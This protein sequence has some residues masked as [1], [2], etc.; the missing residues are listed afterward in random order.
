VGQPRKRFKDS[1]VTVFNVTSHKTY[2]LYIAEEF[3]SKNIN[4]PAWTRRSRWWSWETSRHSR[5]RRFIIV[6]NEH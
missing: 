3:L 2:R 6:S 5:A 1:K 4:Q